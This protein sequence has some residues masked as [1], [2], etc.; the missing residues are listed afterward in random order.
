MA[1]TDLAGG[2]GKTLRVPKQ[3]TRSPSRMKAATVVATSSS[4]ALKSAGEGGPIRPGK[5]KSYFRARYLSSSGCLSGAKRLR[6][7][8][9]TTWRRR[10]RQLLMLILIFFGRRGSLACK[11]GIALD[12]NINSRLVY[13]W[14]DA[15]VNSPGNLCRPLARLNCGLNA[16]ATQRQPI[17]LFNRA[18]HLGRRIEALQRSNDRYA[19]LREWTRSPGLI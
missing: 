1:T 5:R 16:L 13:G 2:R 18:G 19:V 15:L 9:R 7:K 6:T 4:I 10:E 11:T 17:P 3:T 8:A 12:H 14:R